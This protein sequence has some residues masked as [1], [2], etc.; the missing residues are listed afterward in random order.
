MKWAI[1]AFFG[2]LLALLASS[3]LAGLFRAGLT[4]NLMLCAISAPVMQWTVEE[5]SGKKSGIGFNLGNLFSSLLGAGLALIVA[6]FV[7]FSG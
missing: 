2:A 7:G 5:V 1:S 4:L 6:T 3:L